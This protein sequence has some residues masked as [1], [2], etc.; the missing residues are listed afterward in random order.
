MDSNKSF[1]N[2]TTLR[3]HQLRILEIVKAFDDICQRHSIP[4]WIEGGTL[5]GA[6][7]HKGFIPWDDDLD[8]QILYKDLKHLRKILEKEL[9]DNFVIQTNK[10]DKYYLRHLLRIRDIN[11][12]LYV[13]NK[14]DWSDYKYQGVFIDIFAM[15][16]S[17]FLL[18]RI[19]KFCHIMY[20]KR[21][22]MWG[23]LL[24]KNKDFKRLLFY[25]WFK[26]ETFIASVFILLGKL[27]F[28]NR[29]TYCQYGID[30]NGLELSKEDIF[31]LKRV[32]F[33]NIFLNAPNKSFEILTR[34]YGDY[35]KLP[36][37]D[38]QKPNHSINVIFK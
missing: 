33:E 6:V 24:K 36:P 2:Y 35:M 8:V 29:M 38:E 16:S 9:P 15:D 18:T 28:P 31:P 20:W 11:S 14:G 22:M 23:R 21:I 26:L 37:I 27:F 30:Y 7:R 19:R 34:V 5:L 10:T 12:L 25:P 1:D 13:S 3:K 4:Y 32:R 17:L